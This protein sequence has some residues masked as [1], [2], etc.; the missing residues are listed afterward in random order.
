MSLSSAHHVSEKRNNKK[1]NEKSRVVDVVEEKID[2]Y[3]F[4]NSSA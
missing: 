4:V 1:Q 2:A 3:M